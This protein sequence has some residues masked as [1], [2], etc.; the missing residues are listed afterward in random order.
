MPEYLNMCIF[1]SYIS[2]YKVIFIEKNI[3]IEIATYK[4]MRILK[5]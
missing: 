4:E 1:Y 3:R 5:A 2:K